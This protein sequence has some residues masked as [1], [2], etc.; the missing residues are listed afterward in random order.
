MI[1]IRN[2]SH[3][4]GKIKALQ[5]INLKIEAGKITA[6][7]GPNGSG[8]STLFKILATLLKPTSGE[9][10]FLGTALLKDPHAIR[11][12]IGVVF[13]SPSLDKKLT[14]FENMIHQGHLY[15]LS[16]AS[17]SLKVK[18][19]LEEFGVSQRQSS[20]VETLSGGLKRRVEISKALLHDP[21][22]LLFDEPGAGLDPGVRQDIWRFMKK[23]Q[24]EKQVTCLV[25]THLMD[26][27]DQSDDVAILDEGHLIAYDTP[28][29]LKQE[30]GGDVVH[31]TSTNLNLL[32]QNV[33]QTFK[34]PCEILGGE[35]RLAIA[36][37]EDVLP[38]LVK[39]F[40]TLIETAKLSKP[41]L[42]DVF[43]KR[44]GHG[45]RG[46]RT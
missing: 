19:L 8:K 11:K 9:I 12:S 1:E 25:T 7:L 26:E 24:R 30:I 10:H 20:I 16:G 23:L 34:Y 42:E 38:Q 32:K 36:H 3:Q 41:T 28:H 37:G 22:V 2:L 45:L 46:E 17:L 18:A 44:T 14:V 5:N 15:G 31:F 27:A 4:Y 43:M 13:Q 35:L 33:E 6:F 29:T 40:P 21:K 39:A